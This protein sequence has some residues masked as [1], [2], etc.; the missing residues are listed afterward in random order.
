MLENNTSFV[1]C[2]VFWGGQNQDS[3][4]LYSSFLDPLLLSK[5][6]KSVS[7][8][9]SREGHKQK[10]V[11]HLIANNN[12]VI[13]QVLQEKGTIMICGSISMQLEVEQKIDEI[14]SEKIGSSL[15]QLKNEG[16][17]LADC[18]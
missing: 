12:D 18:Y 7:V 1:S 16:S 8:A 4:R 15:I 9:Y 11:Q 13:E 10:Y 14:A 17:I 3:Y 2:Y 6:M 5:K